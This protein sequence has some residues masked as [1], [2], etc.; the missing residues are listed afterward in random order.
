MYISGLRPT[1]LLWLQ[2]RFCEEVEE[3]YTSGDED[4]HGP[5]EE[6]ARDRCRFQRRVLEV[7]ESISFCL[8]PSYRRQVL[9]RLQLS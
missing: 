7:E 9:H 4:R 1:D 5:W 8:A 3:F 6:Y 2:V